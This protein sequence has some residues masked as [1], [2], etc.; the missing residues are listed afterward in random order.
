MKSKTG[1]SSRWRA[2]SFPTRNSYFFGPVRP[3]RVFFDH[4]IR[5]AAIM[6][7]MST[8]AST[9]I[10]LSG[11]SANCIPHLQVEAGILAK[12]APLQVAPVLLEHFLVDFGLD[13]NIHEML[14]DETVLGLHL[15]NAQRLL[16]G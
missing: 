2:G 16:R 5:P 14:V 13:Q 8:A 9:D 3:P 11:P 12:P 1:A 4:Q 7:T 6:T 15:Q 10:L